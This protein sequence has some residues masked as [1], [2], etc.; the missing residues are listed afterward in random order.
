M[1]VLCTACVC[2]AYAGDY[3]LQLLA[4]PSV[5]NFDSAP[6]KPQL[7]AHLE[8]LKKKHELDDVVEATTNE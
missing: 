4:N 3:R 2:H 6:V 7:R 8:D 1:T 5:I